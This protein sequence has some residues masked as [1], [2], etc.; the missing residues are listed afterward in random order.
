[1]GQSAREKTDGFKV[2]NPLSLA[3]Q[4]DIDNAV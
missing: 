3:L 4:P 1:M 2:S